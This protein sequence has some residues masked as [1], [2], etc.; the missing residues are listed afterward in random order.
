MQLFVYIFD[1]FFYVIVV[2][3]G[4]TKK[5]LLDEYFHKQYTYN[6]IIELLAVKHNLHITK[7][8]LER[9]FSHYGLKRK[10]IQESPV[11]LLVAAIINKVFDSGK[12][13]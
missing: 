13:K 10:F 12:K 4:K 5:Q 3:R 2:Q 8:S 7:R 1:D 6:E 9:H 11:E